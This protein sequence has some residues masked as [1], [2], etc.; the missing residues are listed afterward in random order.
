M[1]KKCYFWG[2]VIFNHCLEPDIFLF[3]LGTQFFLWFHWICKV[4]NQIIC[5]QWN[6]Y[7]LYRITPDFT[8]VLRPNILCSESVK[9]IFLRISIQLRNQSLDIQLPCFEFICFIIKKWRIFISIVHQYF[10]N[11]DFC[12]PGNISF[13][14]EEE[15]WFLKE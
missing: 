5:C 7:R 2:V 1:F 13:E 3:T 9:K 8:W 10:E 15:E 6:R 4:V 12:F 14:R 11:E